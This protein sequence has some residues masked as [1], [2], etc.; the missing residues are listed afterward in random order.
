MTVT[1]G[2]QRVDRQASPSLLSPILFLPR[3]DTSLG[4]SR[5]RGDGVFANRIVHCSSQYEGA[6]ASGGMHVGSS[7]MDESGVWRRVEV[8][9]MDCK[10]NKRRADSSAEQ[11][12]Y[13][14]ATEGGRWE[15]RGQWQPRE[16]EESPLFRC[17]G[18]F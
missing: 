8:F 7:R 1:D 4:I 6:C 9:D 18:D 12:L 13:H 10:E 14:S 5:R 11:D 3:N 16:G 15:G 2:G 17:R